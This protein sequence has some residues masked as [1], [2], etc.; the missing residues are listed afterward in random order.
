MMVR[1]LCLPEINWSFQE[2][3]CATDLVKETLQRAR[4]GSVQEALGF[5]TAALGFDSFV[6]GI[7]ANDRRPDAESRTYVMTNQAEAWIRRYDQRAFLEFDPRVELAAEPGYA[8]WEARQFNFDAR[9]RLFLKESAVYGIESRLVIGLCTR[10]PPSYAML[11]LNRARPVLD[12]WSAPERL[13]IAAQASILGKVLSRTVRRFLN[14]QELLFP[15]PRMKLNLREREILALAA[16]GKSSKA[17]A[18]TL[19]IAKITVD[20]HVAT[21]LSKMGA[22]NRYQAVARAIATGLIEV[23]DDVHAEYM[24]A[25]LHAARKVRRTVAAHEEDDKLG[26]AERARVLPMRKFV[27]A[28]STP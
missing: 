26:G 8:F 13:L 14:E 19:G 20:M 17:I 12:Q 16:A 27:R 9:H 3:A 21:M 7:V 6:F 23:P 10:D 28:H 1:K 22:L 4:A 5:A 2:E 25:K 15:A 18:A 11:G 24:S